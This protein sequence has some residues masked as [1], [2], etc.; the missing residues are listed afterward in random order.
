MELGAAGVRAGLGAVEVA[1]VVGAGVGGAAAA[2]GCVDFDAHF[3][4]FIFVWCRGWCLEWSC[5]VE[6]RS[7]REKGDDFEWF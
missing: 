4:S 5:K 3:A 2:E 1:A 6:T 7:R